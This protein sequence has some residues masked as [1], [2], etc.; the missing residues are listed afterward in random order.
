[1]TALEPRWAR[2]NGE[3]DAEPALLDASRARTQRVGTAL[4]ALPMLGNDSSP[5]RRAPWIAQPRETNMTAITGSRSAPAADQA[6]DI[7]KR[8]MTLIYG[9]RTVV[10]RVY[11][12]GG[13]PAEPVWRA[14]MIENRTPL[15][16]GQG[17]SPTP[18]GCFAEAVRFLVADAETRGVVAVVPT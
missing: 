9:G 7:A 4:S 18:E 1:M 3:D 6:M 8:D 11:R 15:R 16:H 17:P 13:A 2:A 12:S 10:V 14:V 5:D